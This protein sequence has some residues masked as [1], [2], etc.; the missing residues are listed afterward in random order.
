MVNMEQRKTKPEIQKTMFSELPLILIIFGS[1]AAGVFLY[2]KL[3]DLVPSHWNFRGEIDAY[4]S[5]F[6]GAFGIPLLNAGIYIMML[7]LPLI[8]PRRENYQKFA[9]AYRVF[10]M[11]FVV[12]MTGVYLLVIVS[13]FGARIPVDRLMMGGISLL[14][15]ILG[16]YMGQIRH[17]YFVGIRTPWTLANEQVWQKTHRLGGRLWVAAGLIG[18]GAALF[19][20]IAG[21]IILGLSL[22]AAT[23]IP[24]VC[25]YIEYKKLQN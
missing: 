11:V 17:N 15:L 1:L 25:S 9:G 6:W 16:N 18:L 14:F 7:L 4:S 13:A 3:P 8:D 20:G 24:I 10:R 19:G 2:D 23:I 5:R 12:F 21:G 22:G